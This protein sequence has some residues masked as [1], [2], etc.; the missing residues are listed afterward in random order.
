MTVNTDPGKKPTH[1]LRKRGLHSSGCCGVEPRGAR[2]DSDWDSRDVGRSPNLYIC[3]EIYRRP[4]ISQCDF[5]VMCFVQQVGEGKDDK[6]FLCWHMGTGRHAY[7]KAKHARQEKKWRESEKKKMWVHHV[8]IWECRRKLRH[9]KL[10]IGKT[11]SLDKNGP[12]MN[13]RSRQ[14]TTFVVLCPRPSRK[15]VITIVLLDTWP[16]RIEGWCP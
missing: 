10:F 14:L 13:K 15:T 8:C 3:V 1:C 9:P 7:Y 2:L 16:R 11:L 12:D 5:P 4:R 6:E